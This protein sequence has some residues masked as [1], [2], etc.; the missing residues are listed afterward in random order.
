M[1]T[2]TTTTAETRQRLDVIDEVVS[3]ELSAD[4]ALYR[5]RATRHQRL[6]PTL[7]DRLTGALREKI[8]VFLMMLIVV[9]V[10]IVF[11]GDEEK[12]R[13]M[14]AAL[15]Q[16][17]FLQIGGVVTHSFTQNSTTNVTT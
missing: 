15:T 10:T 2:T 5:P 12:T 11:S 6:S 14:I 16:T 8:P 4:D 17:P 9:S 3:D 7:S 13:S 1:T